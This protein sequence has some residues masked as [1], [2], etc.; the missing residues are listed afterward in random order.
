MKNKKTTTLGIRILTEEKKLLQN[1][2]DKRGLT[3]SE[4]AKEMISKTITEKVVG[5]SSDKNGIVEKKESE[6]KEEKELDDFLKSV[7]LF[8]EE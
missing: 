6:N 2:A 7:I 4:V 3:L 8:K 1:E 5:S